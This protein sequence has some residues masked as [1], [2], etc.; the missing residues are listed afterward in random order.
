MKE[1]VGHIYEYFFE[2]HIALNL[3]WLNDAVTFLKTRTIGDTVEDMTAAVYEQWLYSGLKES[4]MSNLQHLL[5]QCQHNS[6]DFHNGMILQ[7]EWIL[8][9][10]RSLYS[11]WKTLT[12]EFEDNTGFNIEKEEQENRSFRKAD[13]RM[14]LML[15]SDGVTELRAI[16]YESLPFISLLTLPGCKVLLRGEVKFRH[17][18]LLLTKNNFFVIGGD[19]EYLANKR[20]VEVMASKLHSSASVNSN[21]VTASQ[22]ERLHS[23][24]VSVEENNFGEN[25]L[26]NNVDI[27]AVNGHLSSAKPSMSQDRIINCNNERKKKNRDTVSANDQGK[28]EKAR[29]LSTPLENNNCSDNGEKM[30]YNDVV[31]SSSQMP[32]PRAR[33]KTKH[34]ILETKVNE[35]NTH[36]ISVKSGNFDVGQTKLRLPKLCNVQTDIDN[37]KKEIKEEADEE[38]YVIEEPPTVKLK[39]ASNREGSNL[40]S[41]KSEES[42][43]SDALVQNQLVLKFLQLE[44]ILISDAL[45]TSRFCIGSRKRRILVAVVFSVAEPLRI[46]DDLWTMTVCLTD[47]S[48]SSLKCIISHSVLLQLI[49]LTPHEAKAIRASND[50][51]RRREGT[52]RL[53]SVKETVE[54]L[55]IVWDVEFYAAGKTTPVVRGLKIS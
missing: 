44:I 43:T 14:L 15:L 8:D 47:E 46:V 37:L 24:L 28:S 29:L 45:K 34:N 54:R 55:D 25:K 33:L 2:R 32:K 10:S 17:G 30:N 3:E 35:E 7:I 6:L 49:G 16:E 40:A 20:P 53:R 13:K 19:T 31:D 23:L 26:A 51:A 41:S 12:Y 36:K 9:I 11:Q 52:A 27:I 48:Y 21:K 4:S 1:V 50:K 39:N 38:I 18:T 42:R 5:L 22:K